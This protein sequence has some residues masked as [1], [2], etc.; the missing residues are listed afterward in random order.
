MYKDT[1]PIGADRDAL[2]GEKLGRFRVRRF[3]DHVDP[4]SKAEFVGSP[5]TVEDV[6]GG[7]AA[8]QASLFSQPEEVRQFQRSSNRACKPGTSGT[9]PVAF[10]TMVISQRSGTVRCQNLI[11]GLRVRGRRKR[12]CQL[13]PTK[14]AAFLGR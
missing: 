4:T 8:C 12:G 7:A 2:F 14:A 11:G 5:Q 9:R 13:Q 1:P 3:R 10:A 6:D